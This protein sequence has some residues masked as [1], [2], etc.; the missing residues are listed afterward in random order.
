MPGFFLS[1]ALSSPW[2]SGE[3]IS[4]KSTLTRDLLNPGQLLQVQ[5]KQSYQRGVTSS[6]QTSPFAGNPSSN[7]H[8]PLWQPLATCGY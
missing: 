5:E 3:G 2:S 6:C 1:L 4:V 8:S 7:L